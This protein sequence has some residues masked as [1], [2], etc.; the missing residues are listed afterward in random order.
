[1]ST[2]L[3][4][5]SHESDRLLT[6]SPVRNSYILINFGDMVNNATSDPSTTTAYIQLL[7]ITNATEAS[8][9][10]THVRKSS[11]NGAASE[12]DSSS[13]SSSKSAMPLWLIGFIVGIGLLILAVAGVACFCRRRR[14]K[15][16]LA[17]S[18][19]WL[20]NPQSYQPI[21]ELSPKAGDDMHMALSTA[22][23]YTPAYTPEY[24][25]A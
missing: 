19:A 9:D 25:T 7:P 21:R 1:M 18:T 3:S 6:L 20:A 23:G 11:R 4:P 12:F 13:S 17:P 14:A 8:K 10:F 24:K 2:V 22:P 5:A 15:N 16:V